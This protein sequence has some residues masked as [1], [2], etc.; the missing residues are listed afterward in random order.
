MNS[1]TPSTHLLLVLATPLI[2]A[3]VAWV[4]GARGRHAVRQSAVVTAGLTLVLAI[5]MYVT[6][7]ID[8]YARDRG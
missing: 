5:V 7:N 1:L 6:R 4:L 8:W 2:G 3:V